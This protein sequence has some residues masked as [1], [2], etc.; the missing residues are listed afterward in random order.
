MW[1]Q[2]CIRN[3]IPVSFFEWIVRKAWDYA[4]SVPGAQIPPNSTYIET[5]VS[6]GKGSKPFFELSNQ[7]SI[8]QYLNF[9][10][11]KSFSQKYLLTDN[12]FCGVFDNY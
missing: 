10:N 12:Y 1:S 4:K 9:V 11:K 5:I 7:W 3:F 6:L 8:M 2:I